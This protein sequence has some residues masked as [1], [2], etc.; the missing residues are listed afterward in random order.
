MKREYVVPEL[1]MIEFTAKDMVTASI[2]SN[3]TGKTPGTTEG[4]TTTGGYTEIDYISD[5]LGGGG[6][7]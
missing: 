2:L 3:D 6:G 1:I 5:L 4:G 7:D